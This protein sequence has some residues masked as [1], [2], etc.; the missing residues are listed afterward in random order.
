MKLFQF[1]L[2]YDSSTSSGCNS[3]GNALELPVPNNDDKNEEEE[4]NDDACSVSSTVSNIS[5]LSDL[6]N[7]S[8]K[9]WKPFAGKLKL[10]WV[11]TNFF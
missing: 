11:K 1:W 2:L 3:F 9:D 8:G 10:G 7:L 4:E 6:S 5:G